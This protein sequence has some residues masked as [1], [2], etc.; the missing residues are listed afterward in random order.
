MGYSY[1]GRIVEFEELS[2]DEKIAVVLR[3]V[4]QL[5]FT[6]RKLSTK[7]DALIEKRPEIEV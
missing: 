4:N 3:A 2:T 7:V 5:E 6:V 1:G